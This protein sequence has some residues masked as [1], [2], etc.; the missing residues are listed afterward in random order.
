MHALPDCELGAIRRNMVT[1]FCHLW[2]LLIVRIIC[3]IAMCS[4]MLN[5]YVCTD[6]SCASL[7][8]VLW[9]LC[10]WSHVMFVVTLHVDVL[11]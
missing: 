7:N 9:Y 5:G 2:C 4:G 8:C 10:Q 3:L 6:L 1:V 11:S